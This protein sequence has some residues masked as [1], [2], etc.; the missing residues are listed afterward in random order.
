MSD[1]ETQMV[2]AVLSMIRQANLPAATA[3]GN[4]AAGTANVPVDGENP[5]A[6]LN[7]KLAVSQ[8]YTATV[9]QPEQNGQAVLRI[10]N[11]L[12]TASSSEIPL[13]QGQ[14]ITVEVTG[15]GDVIELKV[16]PQTSQQDIRAQFIKIDLPRQIPLKA[17]VQTLNQLSGLIEK[18]IDPTLSQPVTVGNSNEKNPVITNPANPGNVVNEAEKPQLQQRLLQL[19][20]QIDNAIPRV[21]DL[22]DP[23][24]FSKL[25]QQSGLFLEKSLAAGQYSGSDL[26]ANL[27]QVAAQL[28]VLAEQVV[29]AE[30]TA[31][32]DA[33]SRLASARSG[34]MPG[35][36]Q[37]PAGAASLSVANTTLPSQPPTGQAAAQNTLSVPRPADSSPFMAAEIS[38]K[39]TAVTADRAAPAAELIRQALSGTGAGTS[40]PASIGQQPAGNIEKQANPNTQS[41]ATGAGT[42]SAAVP[43][44]SAVQQATS[45]TGEIQQV[46]SVTD[47]A[48]LSASQQA[49]RALMT[50]RPASQATSATATGDAAASLLSQASLLQAAINLLPKGELNIL[51]QQLLFRKAMAG[52][53]NSSSAAASNKLSPVRQLLQAVESGL[54]RLQTQQL[55]SVPVDDTTRQ[56]WQFEIPLREQREIHSLM[57]RI[58]QEDRHDAAENS[59]STW[60]VCLNM[61]MEE[62]GHIHSKVRLT[63]ENVSTHFW[64]EQE[65]TVQ[66]ISGH[67]DKLSKNFELLGLTVQHMTAALGKPPDPVEIIS[68]ESSLLDE[69]A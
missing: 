65:K 14:H 44:G 33:Q 21:S 43:P 62:M 11:Q 25:L 48:G 6:G 4:A 23:Q 53:S 26:K 66:K 19:I 5:P 63:G 42:T 52:Q 32:A 9:V 28:R 24:Q 35:A 30:K 22:K 3:N 31:S 47:K 56:V 20:R 18:S 54:A 7:D 69:Q 37:N 16:I 8:Q 40:R 60:T 41:A 46:S 38:G 67:L 10:L 59:G 1:L 17:L 57:M 36:T 68:I 55:A 51:L 58:E 64:A 39:P 27:L 61:D 29:L 50:A 13:K 2:K 15:K 49:Q 12:V 45:A 34:A